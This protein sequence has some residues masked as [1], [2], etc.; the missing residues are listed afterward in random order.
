MLVI[1]LTG[2]SGAG[3]GEV[4][5]LFASFRIPVMDA[6]KIYHQMLIPPSD[7]L[8]EIARHFGPG[9]LLPDGSLDRKKLA[10]I[11]FSDRAELDEL[12]RITHA[13][14][15]RTI[16]RR[17]EYYK[18]DGVRAVVLDAP[19]LFEA[20]ADK[21][22]NILVS[23]LANKEDRIRRIVSRDGITREEA[24][25]RLSSQKSDA[26][27]RANSD[28]VIENNGKLEELLPAVKKILTETGALPL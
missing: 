21:D 27:F 23:V 9:I 11:V 19:Q 5:D 26:F 2:P 24:E 4:S 6:D 18:N 8:S 15:M 28:Y 3:K 17:L 1:G 14:V 16:R 13:F 12:N 20:G 22:C 25:L 7:C 10:S